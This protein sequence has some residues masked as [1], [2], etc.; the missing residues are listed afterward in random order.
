MAREQGIRENLPQF[1]WLVLNTMLVGLTVG[2]ERTV[3]PLV[4][5]DVYH[6]GALLTLSFIASFGLAK[7]P[8]NL[9]AG[10]LSDR[11][12]R[13]PVLAAGWALG[14]P[15]VALVLLVHAWW[16][17]IVANIF[18]GANQAFAWTMTVTA[19]L[20][21]AG[22][23]QRGIAMGINEATGYLGV[24]LATWLSGDLARH[25]GLVTAPFVVGAGVVAAGLASSLW[26]IHDTR[27]WVALEPRTH[28]TQHQH[29]YTAWQSFV[30]TSFQEPTLS[31]A[32]WAG[33]TNKLADTVAWGVVP[34]FLAARH[35]PVWAIA[36]ISGSYAAAWGLSQFATGLLSD[37]VGR[38]RPIVA[39]FVLLGTGL[40]ALSAVRGVFA[41]EMTAII[42]G[43]GMALLYPNL[44]STVSD[45][46]PPDQRGSVLGVYRLWRDGGYLVGGLAVGALLA[47]V[48]A[49]DTILLVGV[50]VGLMAAV[51]TFRMRETHGRQARSAQTPDP[52]QSQSSP[53]VLRR[54]QPH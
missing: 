26:V 18:L 49:A 28:A 43:L 4:G 51:L 19:Q 46:A 15:M 23:Q 53:P 24:A 10:R 52:R 3:V 21:L 14:I 38:K 22:P 36:E 9:V 29:P 48:G 44:N 5:Q 16:A 47:A 33:L 7:A 40:V 13:Q 6:V 45:I 17:I 42:S 30:Y 12:G 35:L 54:R 37:R 39:G 41:W 31:A 8:L 2:I 11:V 27:P 25:W 1:L 34:L 20:D 32:A 50:L